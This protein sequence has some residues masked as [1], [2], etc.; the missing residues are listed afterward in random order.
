MFLEG[1]ILPR[2]ATRNTSSSVTIPARFARRINC[3]RTPRN[4]ASHKYWL[5]E[6]L[7]HDV[8]L[9][10]TRLGRQRAALGSKRVR[11]AHRQDRAQ[12]LPPARGAWPLEYTTGLTPS[13]R[14]QLEMRFGGTAPKRRGLANNKAWPLG[15]GPH[16]GSCTAPRAGRI[17]ALDIASHNQVH[18]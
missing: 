13:K 9:G 1:R 8:T 5:T 4:R 3:R 15:R 7:T 10:S 2:E 14:G 16:S 17:W 6:S 18:T 11:Q 12:G